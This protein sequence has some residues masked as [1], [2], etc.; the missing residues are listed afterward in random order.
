MVAT[1]ARKLPRVITCSNCGEGNPERARFC[2]RCGSSLIGT[3]TPEEERRIVTVLFCEAVGFAGRVGD[4]EDLKAGLASFHARLKRAWRGYGGTVDKFMG[5]VV[6][7]VFGAPVQHEDDP[8]RAVLAALRIQR[9]VDRLND[10]DRRDLRLMMSANTGE[11]VVAF[12]Y[13]FSLEE[14]QTLLGAGRC[15]I[16]SERAGDALER[17]RRARAILSPL[18]VRPLLE[19]IDDLLGEETAL[20]S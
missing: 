18:G 3:P 16:E 19:E 17:L 14:G 6:M 10:E 12:G 15:L 1:P 2:L 13:G 7:C 20:S 5:P 8:H 4:P 11:V 9:F